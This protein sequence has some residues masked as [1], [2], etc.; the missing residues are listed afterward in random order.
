MQG[1]RLC[2]RLSLI[3][4]VLSMFM[5]YS[6]C[7]FIHCTSIYVYHVCTYYVCVFTLHIAVCLSRIPVVC[8]LAFIIFLFFVTT[9]WVNDW[10]LLLYALRA[11]LLCERTL[12]IYVCVSDNSV[13]ATLGV[14]ESEVK[15]D[16]LLFFKFY[17]FF[18]MDDGGIFIRIKCKY[19]CEGF[20][21]TFSRFVWKLS[22]IFT[23][24][25]DPLT[26]HIIPDYFTILSI[27][28]N[29]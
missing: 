23:K 10:Q 18:A 12:Y 9:V 25:Y 6:V 17:W 1:R 11:A 27:P 29:G 20:G 5:L 2:A 22:E 21:T 26:R 14:W 13:S 7:L 28:F 15:G 16:N 24:M 4:L 8:A 19:M 3:F